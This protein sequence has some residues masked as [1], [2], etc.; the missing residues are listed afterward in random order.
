VGIVNRSLFFI[1]V[2][3]VLVIAVQLSAF[4]IVHKK[5]N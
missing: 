2:G 1:V 4:F 5:S 3:C